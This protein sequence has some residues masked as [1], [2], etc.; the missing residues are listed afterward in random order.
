MRPIYLKVI[1]WF[2]SML[3]ALTTFT[4]ITSLIFVRTNNYNYYFNGRQER[5]L[6]NEKDLNAITLTAVSNTTSAAVIHDKKENIDHLYMWGANDYGQQ[7]NGY[8][9]P[10]IFIDHPEEVSYLTMEL[11]AGDKIVKLALSE[12]TSAAVVHTSKDDRDHLYMWGANNTAQQGN[13]QQGESKSITRPMEVGNINYLIKGGGHITNISLTDIATAVSIHID[14]NDGKDHLYMWGSNANGVQGNGENDST[15]FIKTPSP[16]NGI[17]LIQGDTIKQ[18]SMSKTTSSAVIHTKL[19]NKDILYMWG[20]NNHGQQGISPSDISI[21]NPKAVE[22]LNDKLQTN[23]VIRKISM[24]ENNSSAIIAHAD[25]TVIDC[26]YNWG[27]VFNKSASMITGTPVL[28]EEFSYML[29][30]GEHLNQISVSN[31]T[32]AALLKGEAKDYLYMWGYND[33]GQQGNGEKGSTSIKIPKQVV[34]LSKEILSGEYIENVNISEKTSSVLIKDVVKGDRLYM[35]GANNKG[36]QGKGTTNSTA[37]I[38]IPTIVSLPTQPNPPTPG[39]T[40]PA[41]VEKSN[42]NFYL[43]IALGVSLFAIV[44]GIIFLIWFNKKNKKNSKHNYPIQ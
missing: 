28:V 31:N 8:Q 39:P 11:E 2:V 14:K 41:P 3:I 18:I 4:G 5:L 38:T 43:I 10:N 44:A 26:I 29:R 33:S 17:N 37:S 22:A 12:F 27:V 42:I 15:T 20:R 6:T 13:G 23:D 21:L 25:S 1:K 40:P 16:V 32:N 36:Q 30:N 9:N 7:G 19:N 35:W 24:S 34:N